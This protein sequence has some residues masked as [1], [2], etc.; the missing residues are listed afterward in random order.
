MT[1]FTSPRDYQSERI[2]CMLWNNIL[3]RSTKWVLHG[4]GDVCVDSIHIELIY[5]NVVFFYKVD[6]VFF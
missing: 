6:I 2:K 4:H 3:F 5:N 1:F